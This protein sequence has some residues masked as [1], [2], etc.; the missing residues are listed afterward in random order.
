MESSGVLCSSGTEEATFHLFFSCPFSQECWRSLNILWDLT[1]GFFS[2]M[3]EAKKNY[4]HGFF[5][6]IF[7][8][9]CW[10]IW[11][12]RNAF[13]FNRGHPSQQSW[14]AGFLEEACLQAHRMNIAQKNVFSGLISSFF[15]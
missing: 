14:R 6:E 7:L 11:K 8:L 2:M 3:D 10:H 9:G 12:Q 13:I 15:V 5:M 4:Q 1:L